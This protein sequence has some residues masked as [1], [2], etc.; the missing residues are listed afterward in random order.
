MKF[1]ENSREYSQA[2]REVHLLL[3]ASF[4]CKLVYVLF[5]ETIMKRLSP[6]HR[7]K[8]QMSEK[9]RTEI[10]T[11]VNLG[12]SLILSEDDWRAT[13]LPC[14]VWKIPKLRLSS[15]TPAAQFAENP[16][17]PH[18]LVIHLYPSRW[19]KAVQLF[20]SVVWPY[21]FMALLWFRASSSTDFQILRPPF[22]PMRLVPKKDMAVGQGR[23]LV[24]LCWAA[25]SVSCLPSTL[26]PS[27]VM[28]W[29]L[30]SNP[31][32]LLGRHL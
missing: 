20:W 2:R 16:A 15:E 29:V 14:P 1:H 23:D 24:N 6:F 18:F 32:T 9:G 26:S 13:P 22:T 10:P 5:T 21:C 27:L 12:W 7:W 19:I 11:D 8:N 17:S 31:C 25:I 3:F 30:P 28:Y 4:S